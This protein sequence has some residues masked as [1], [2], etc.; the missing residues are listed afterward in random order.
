MAVRDPNIPKPKEVTKMTTQGSG[1]MSFIDKVVEARQKALALKEF[2]DAL[3]GGQDKGGGGGG[4]GGADVATAIVTASMQQQKIL[5]D[6]LQGQIGEAN[7]Q[8]LAAQAERE[9]ANTALYNERIVI[10]K[11]EQEKLEETAAAAKAAGAPKSEI[12]AYKEVRKAIIDEI[13]ELAKGAPKD[14]GPRGMSEGTMV[15]L[16]KMEMDQARVLAEIQATNLAAQREFELRIRE[17]DENA[18]RRWAE[19][20]DSKEFREQGLSGVQDLLAAVGDGI[21]RD[22]G[23]QPAAPRPG[24]AAAKPSGDGQELEAFIRSFPCSQCQEKVE[25]EPGATTAVCQ[26]CGTEYDIQVKQ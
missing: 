20:K 17:F 26:G 6:A 24:Q 15:T 12:E 16:K 21:S 25:I 18:Q 23:G 10:L 1:D 19:Y 22:R 5:F 3:H 7:K 8:L 13:G 2:E 11:S 4:G 9:K 14:E